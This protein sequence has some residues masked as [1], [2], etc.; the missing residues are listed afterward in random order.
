[1]N[2]RGLGSRIG[3][4][5]VELMVVIAIVGII[6]ALLLPAVQAAREAARR[7]QCGNHLRN[8][9]LA[10]HHHHDAHKF[11]PSGGWGSNW[12]GDPDMGFGRS[13]PGSWMFS[14]LPFIEEEALFSLGKSG[15]RQWPVPMEKKQ[16]LGK[17]AATPLPI[18][19]CPSRRAPKAYPANYTYVGA[20][21]WFHDGGD[22]ARNDYVG[23]VGSGSSS[24][25]MI[26]ATY[27]NQDTY[28]GWPNASDFN[29]LVFMRSEVRIRHI[30]D[31][32]SQTYM[33]G[34]KNVMVEA[35]EAAVVDNGDDEGC[36]AGHNGDVVRSTGWGPQP[37]RAGALFFDSWGS[38]HPGVFH[39][40]FADGSVRGLSFEIEAEIHR[41]LGTRA[42]G[43]MIDVSKL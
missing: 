30:T 40:M 23:S 42:G 28:S 35:Y 31:G 11:F 29:G 34:E 12:M 36:F 24:W 9:G 32:T 8:L 26:Y 22:L 39:M 19:H 33:V 7:S 13:Q 16:R 27:D 15:S 2:A 5:L 6:I 14:V 3:F 20:F 43:E 25:S 41:A 21:N 10:F 38:A 18:F 37:D 1:M 17:V 4:T